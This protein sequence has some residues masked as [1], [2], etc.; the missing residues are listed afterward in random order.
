MFCSSSGGRIASI[1]VQSG[2]FTHARWLFLI[3]VIIL[4][5]SVTLPLYADPN[6][7]EH[8][9]LISIDT[10]RADHLQCYG[11]P[12][13]TTPVIDQLARES[14]LFTNAISPVPIT[15]PAH[16]SML[17]GVNPPSHGVHDNIG[18]RLSESEVTLAELL[19]KKGFKTGAIIS[20]F[21]LNSLF[22]LR[23]GFDDYYNTSENSKSETQI[24][25]RRSKETSRL[26]LDWLTKYSQERFFLFLHYYDPHD[27]YRPPE[28]YRTQFPDNFYAGEIAYTDNSIGLV[29]NKLK[30]L[31][32][33][34]STLIILT[35]DHGEMLGEHGEETHTFFIYQSALK[36]PLI[37]KLSSLS[38]PRLIKQLAGIIDIVPTICSLLGIECPGKVQGSDLSAYLGFKKQTINDRN[39]YCESFAPTRFDAN[40]LFGLINNEWKYIMTTRPELYELN[41]DPRESNNLITTI[42]QK[43]NSF[44]SSLEHILS[45]ARAGKN[46]DN[47]FTLDQVE[48][49]QLHALGYVTDSGVSATFMVDQTMADPKDQISYKTAIIKLE[50]LIFHENFNEAAIIGKELLLDRKDSLQ[51]LLTMA[52]ISEGQNDLAQAKTYLTQAINVQPENYLPYSEIARI[53]SEMNR[54]EEAVDYFKKAIALEPGIPMLLN[55]LAVAQ[56]SI[57]EIDQAIENF[58]KALQINPQLAMVQSNLGHTWLK[59]GKPEKAIKHLKKSL[60]LNQFQPIQLDALIKILS[61]LNRLP[62]ESGFFDELL[63]HHPQ[64]L[65]LLIT[66][67]NEYLIVREFELALKYLNKILNF[68]PNLS[69][70]RKNLGIA[71]E[72]L[73]RQ[74]EALEHYLFSVK[75]KPDQADVLASIANIYLL[76]ED[77]DA[78]MTY[79]KK[80]V[81]FWPDNPRLYYFMGVVLIRKGEHNKAIHQ[82]QNALYREPEMPAAHNA[83]GRILAHLGQYEQAASHY[84]ESLEAAAEQPDTLIEISEVYYRL[85]K[86]EKTVEYLKKAL[87]FK[88]EWPQGLNNLAWLKAT[89]PDVQIF[90]PEG[91]LR[92]ATRAC[93]LT[94]YKKPYFLGTLAAAFAAAGQ[95]KAAIKI[96]EKK[97]AIAKNSGLATMAAETQKMIDLFKTGQPYR[98]PD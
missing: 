15:L 18:Q 4:G 36:V 83:L 17:T 71:L 40:P 66:L 37:F 8:I 85:G 82:F 70:V 28:P 3:I 21:V 58:Q 48:R 20:S 55:S 57:G 9:L 25:E 53:L 26:A 60:Q 41:Q 31:K 38:Q 96:A 91:A 46:P 13:N 42:P 97:L 90:D 5:I 93:E 78:A 16:C 49:Q 76:L 1:K 45:Q 35:G 65:K 32:L 95:F 68:N 7:I 22:G 12:E 2:G 77:L 33:Y 87:D 14:V 44:Q 27:E 43:G 39:L 73:D 29:L 61:Q 6:P 59:K 75:I 94:E 62:A 47:K 64:D 11:F 51:A 89:S 69:T 80:A 63:I 86:K 84:S 67:S 81:K 23:Q 79:Y 10:C 19:Q 34:D 56:L 52:K 72:S 98:A 74:E 30:E 54:N 88:P 92:M 50:K 24:P